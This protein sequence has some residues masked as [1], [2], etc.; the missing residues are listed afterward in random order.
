LERLGQALRDGETIGISWSIDATD[1]K[2][3]HVP[4][5]DQRQ[6]LDPYAV[7][8][9]RLLLLTGARLREIL[10][11]RWDFIDSERGLIFLPTSKTGRKTIVLNTAALA[12]ID[13][14]RA[15]AGSNPFVIRSAA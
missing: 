4:K 15:R 7:A 9:I 11:L 12:L 5:R 1:P 13:G 6:L 10:T 8:A 3:K 2:W 14:L